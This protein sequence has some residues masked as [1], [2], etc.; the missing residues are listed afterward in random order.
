MSYQTMDYINKKG[1]PNLTDNIG[2]NKEIP[3]QAIVT[4]PGGVSNIF[5]GNGGLYGKGISSSD[6]YGPSNPPYVY[7]EY[8][9][10][11]NSG[12]SASR[13]M[14]YYGNANGGTANTS[15]YSADR[16]L[17]S[18]TPVTPYRL[19]SLAYIPSS[20]TSSQL[21]MG[22]QGFKNFPPFQTDPGFV[23]R[24]G[25]QPLK[26][27][28]YNPIN[29]IENFEVDDEYEEIE[30]PPLKTATKE[31]LAIE[32]KSV[33]AVA[34]FFIFL[35]ALFAFGLWSETGMLFIQQHLHRGEQV[36]WQKML[37]YAAI[38]TVVFMLTIYFAGIPL[39]SFETI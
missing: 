24:Y 6:I 19:Q 22:G 4:S 38:V 29:N 25:G 16:T 26:G 23:N 9:N 7:G 34:V 27:A 13:A 35:M 3:N 39:T 30:K 11:Y 12:P 17:P 10:V 21:M 15:Y 5:H 36:K 28:D 14:G 20:S 33:S 1:F 8:G 37:M 32:K 2:Y 18:Q 31:H